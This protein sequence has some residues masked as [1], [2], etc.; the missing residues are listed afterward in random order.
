VVRDDRAHDLLDLD[1]WRVV[2]T[3]DHPAPRKVAFARMA[4]LNAAE[5]GASVTRTAS[6]LGGGSAIYSSSS[7]QRHMRDAEAITHH[8]SVAQG[9][10][11]DVGR[12]LMGRKPNAPMF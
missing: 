10:W 4:A 5:V 12:V 8:F 11:E 2:S 1:L 7:L 6:L 3:G 9:V